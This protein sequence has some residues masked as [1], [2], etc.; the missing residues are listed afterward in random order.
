MK[1]IEIICIG[2]FVAGVGFKLFHFPGSSVLLIGSVVVLL[3]Y[4]LIQIVKGFHGKREISKYLAGF[5][6][7]ILLV[8]IL[9]RLQFW[10]FSII[11]LYLS[12]VFSIG[13][14]IIY[15]LNRYKLNNQLIFFIVVFV[16]SIMLF[17][18][19]SYQ[20]YEIY[21]FKDKKE[22]IHHKAL[23]KYA[24]FLYKA[25]KKEEAEAACLQAI[26]NFKEANKET[27]DNPLNNR[28]KSRY[29]THLELIRR[30]EWDNYNLD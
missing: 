25:G 9:S 16:I 7:S 24:W 5:S 1:I 17:N 10:S 12:V 4:Y 28:L 8:Y 6:A 15:F 27:L 11:A 13:L 19:H 21:M 23:N 22:N 26:E 20:I 14:I 18:L 3:A 30:N 2:F 29:E